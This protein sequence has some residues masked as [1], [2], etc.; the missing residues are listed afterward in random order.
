MLWSYGSDNSCGGFH[1]VAYLLDV[2]GLLR[3]HLH[4]EYFVVWLEHFADCAYHAEGSVVA[5]GGH[6]GF[7]AFRQYALHIVLSGCFSVAAGDAYY[8]QRGHSFEA[9]AGVVVISFVD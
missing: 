5:A 9:L 3:A 1:E 7:V 4:D 8:F 2:A 6:K